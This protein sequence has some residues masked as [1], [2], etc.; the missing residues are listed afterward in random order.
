MNDKYKEISEALEAARDADMPP[1]QIR[2]MRRLFKIDT[3]WQPTKKR[4][5]PEHRKA[6]RKMQKASRRKNRKR[7]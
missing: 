1:D 2:E 4:D 6:R 7:K 5:T 3:D